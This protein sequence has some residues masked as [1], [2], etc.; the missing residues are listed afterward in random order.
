MGGSAMTNTRREELVG[1]LKT[2]CLDPVMASAFQEAERRLRMKKKFTELENVVN[3]ISDIEAR[4]EETEKAL[5]RELKDIEWFFDENDLSMP[6]ITAYVSDNLGTIEIEREERCV[7][8]VVSR[9]RHSY[10]GN[11][12]LNNLRED[13]DM[14]ASQALILANQAIEMSKLCR[15]EAEMINLIRETQAKIKALEEE[16]KKK[17]K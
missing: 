7:V 17:K 1:V 6:S 11:T 10:R 9:R 2:L 12:A 16:P 8:A 4:L 3:I 14:T 15:T 5:E 13:V